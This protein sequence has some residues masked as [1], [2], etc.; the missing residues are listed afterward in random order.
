MRFLVVDDNK[1]NQLVTRKLLQQ[2]E[3]ECDVVENGLEAIEAAK[4]KKYHCILMDIHMPKMNGYEAT[5]RI[6]RF[7]QDIVIIALTATTSEEVK[8]NISFCD[9]DDYILKPF[10]SEDFI[11]TIEN[12]IVNRA[13][14]NR[15][16]A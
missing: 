8:N 14:I 3:L 15:E 4:E 10:Y 2:L 13:D 6:R 16:T 12:A 11:N 9:M 7:D 1:I 5:Q